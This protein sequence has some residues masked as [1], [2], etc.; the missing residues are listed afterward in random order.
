M[1]LGIS[2]A[3]WL[4]CALSLIGC[5]RDR[6][7][8]SMAPGDVSASPR[9]LGIEERTVSRGA[10]RP[11][12][13]PNAAPANSALTTSSPKTYAVDAGIGGFR[14]TEPDGGTVR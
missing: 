13:A 4:G 14:A 3:T 9:P 12:P 5:E 11:E 2:L 6:T 8:D 1:R 7:N 10:T